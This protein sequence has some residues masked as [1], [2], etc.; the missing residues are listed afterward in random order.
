VNCP[1]TDIG[2]S[3]AGAS[4]GTAFPNKGETAL[5]E[6]IKRKSG[7]FFPNP[8]NSDRVCKSSSILIEIA[9]ASI[10]ILP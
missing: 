1:F 7:A 3:F 2:T 8:S 6:E 10:D 4:K 9:W 5:L